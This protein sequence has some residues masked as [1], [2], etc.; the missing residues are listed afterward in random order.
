MPA[1]K[2]LITAFLTILALVACLVPASAGEARSGDPPGRPAEEGKPPASGRVTME[3][4][5]GAFLVSAIGGRGTLYFQGKAH[6]FTLGG[7]GVGG[8]GGDVATAEGS[9]YN[10]GDVDAFPG[11]YF[12][13]AGG[14]AV[15]KGE[16]VLWLRNARGV[17]IELRSRTTGAMMNVGAEG[18]AIVMS[19]R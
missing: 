17:E 9:V 3:Y 10:L 5:Q 18:V 8:L 15:W 6:G 1:R 19:G 14:H 13:L 7:A 16:G 2:P 4:A 11:V 12:K